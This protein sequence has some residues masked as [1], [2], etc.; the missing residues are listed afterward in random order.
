[1]PW[2]E[3]TLRWLTPCQLA[4]SNLHS[5]SVAPVRLCDLLKASLQ[6]LLPNP[7]QHTFS[8]GL[9]TLS[10]QRE[11]CACVTLGAELS[12]SFSFWQ[13]GP[14]HEARQQVKDYHLPYNNGKHEACYLGGLVKLIFRNFYT[15]W[16]QRIW[17][18]DVSP[19]TNWTLLIDLG[20]VSLKRNVVWE[21]NVAVSSCGG[22]QSRPVMENMTGYYVSC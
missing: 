9:S 10:W 20:H 8:P 13:I 4:W 15:F 16:C 1:M 22:K 19:L 6:K 3:K 11:L 7:L 2:K 12:G 5:K 14:R 18:F 17:S 21:D